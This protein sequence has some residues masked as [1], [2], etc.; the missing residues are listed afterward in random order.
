M[1]CSAYLRVMEE[2]CVKALAFFSW[3]NA[4]CLHRHCNNASFYSPILSF[5]LISLSPS[6]AAN[7]TQLYHNRSPSQSWTTNTCSKTAPS[8]APSKTP[9]HAHRPARP[10]RRPG[11]AACVPARAATAPSGRGCMACRRRHCRP[12]AKTA[13]FLGGACTRLARGAAPDAA[14]K[15][16][17]AGASLEIRARGRAWVS[18]C[19]GPFSWRRRAG[20]RAC[21]ARAA[22]AGGASG[23]RGMGGMWRGF[24]SFGHS[25]AYREAGFENGCPG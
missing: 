19:R 17:E 12:L 9:Q 20:A 8:R 3:T 24:S 5:L 14:L 22:A 18:A 10:E 7:S 21:E 13:A 1:L 6:P 11:A 23:G 4:S 16:A 15:P 25:L 2:R